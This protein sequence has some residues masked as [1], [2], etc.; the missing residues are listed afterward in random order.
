MMRWKNELN[1]L[2]CLWMCLLFSFPAFA[3]EW[4]VDTIYLADDY[5][6]DYLEDYSVEV[7]SGSDAT[8]SNATVSG[9]S[10]SGIMLLSDR[11]PYDSGSISSTV[12]NYMSDVLPKLGNVHYVL[13]RSGQYEYRLYYSKE[14]E[15]DG[16]G[17]FSASEAEYISYDSRF[18]TWLSGSESDFALEAGRTMVYSDLG[19]YP[20]LSSGE[21]STWLLVAL[22]AAYFVFVIIR[23]FLSPARHVI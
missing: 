11:T 18:Y 14:L 7:A 9:S 19:T 12:V 8:D 4:V 20:M 13:F 2:F 10:N 16:T 3:D 6:E 5:Q 15:N 1:L 17:G 22:G 23:S 21:T